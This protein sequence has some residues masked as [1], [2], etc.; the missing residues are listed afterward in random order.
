MAGDCCCDA[1]TQCDLTKSNPGSCVGVCN[2]YSLLADGSKCY[3]KLIYLA[4]V[5][6]SWN[7]P[8]QFFFFCFSFLFDIVA[9]VTSETITHRL[10][11]NSIWQAIPSAHPTLI[12]VTTTQTLATLRHHHQTLIPAALSVISAE[13]TTCHSAAD[14]T[15]RK[16]E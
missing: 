8:Q 9:I 10:E 16:K 12:A 11:N 13:H 2:Y 3:C 5:T 7:V 6:L 1:D 14:A 4:V 15:M